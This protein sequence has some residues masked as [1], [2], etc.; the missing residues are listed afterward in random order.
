MERLR[1]R[2]EVLDPFRVG[3]AGQF[4]RFDW[5]VGQL[6]SPEPLP[7][8]EVLIV[9]AIGLLHPELDGIFDLTIW[10]D[11]DLAVATER[12][13]ARDHLLA[14]DHDRLWDE[15]WVPNERDFAARFDP[16]G[17]ADLLFDAS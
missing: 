10:V 14:R 16:R 13:K 5:E 4:R 3:H 7:D 12:G 9:D 1:L 11:V 6:G 15:V 17:H 2:S 8:A